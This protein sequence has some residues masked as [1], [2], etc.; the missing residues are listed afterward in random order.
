MLKMEYLSQGLQLP[1]FGF[2]GSR[3]PDLITSCIVQYH[4]FKQQMALIQGDLDWSSLS[5]DE[6]DLD[7]QEPEKAGSLLGINTTQMITVEDS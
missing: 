5:T 4:S 3:S 1:Q 2:L 6:I 7:T